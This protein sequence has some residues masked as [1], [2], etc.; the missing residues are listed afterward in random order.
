VL[1]LPALGG[2]HEHDLREGVIL[3]GERLVRHRVEAGPHLRIV[4]DE[5][6]RPRRHRCDQ[7]AADLLR[8][9]T[10]T[11]VAGSIDFTTT[12]DEDGDIVVNGT[13]EVTSCL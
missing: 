2:P 10:S 11:S 8:L 13:F 5:H 3:L 6:A 12:D 9:G 4:A 1:G 7:L